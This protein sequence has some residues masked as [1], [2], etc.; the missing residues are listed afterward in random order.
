MGGF[1]VMVTVKLFNSIVGTHFPSIFGNIQ[2]L[3]FGLGLQLKLWS[4]IVLYNIG[5]GYIYGEP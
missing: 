4:L 1:M 5:R 3:H 2:P